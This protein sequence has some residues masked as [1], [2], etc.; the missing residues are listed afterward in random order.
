MKVT[1]AEIIAQTASFRYPM[2]ITG[3]QP[4]FKVP[5]ISTIYGLLSAAKGEIVTSRDVRVGY[6]FISNGSGY[7]LEKIYELRPSGDVSQNNVITREFLYECTLTL[8]ISDLDFSKHL[9][10]PYYTLL[11]GRQSDLAFVRKVETIE[12]EES[13]NVTINNTIIP[14]DGSIPGQI[15]TLPTG[16]T[17]EF[18]RKPCGVRT[19]VF[20]EASQNTSGYYD[21][22]RKCGVFMHPEYT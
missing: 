12:L 15:V 4:T 16:F 7:D 3:Y 10:N 9:K 8:Y 13:D 20:I 18:H 6:D 1:R 5:P 22:E 14:F 11:L 17:N 2:F 21:Q 19:F